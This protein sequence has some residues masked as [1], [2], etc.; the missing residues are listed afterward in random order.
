MPHVTTDSLIETFS[1]SMGFLREFEGTVQ[2]YPDKIAVVSGDSFITYAALNAK[3]NQLGRFLRRKGVSAEKIVIVYLDRSIE[4]IIAFLG[5]LKAGGVYL[6]LDP[7]FIPQYRLLFIADNAQ[8]AWVLTQVCFQSH[9]P[10][11]SSLV[12]LWEDVC[13]KMT[14]ESTNSFP[15]IAHTDNLAYIMYTS[16]STGTPKGVTV[17][18]K[19]LSHCAMAMQK[20]M[21]IRP[22]DVYLHTASFA[23]SSSIRQL[24]VPLF[25]GATLVIATTTHVRDPHELF[26]LVQKHNVTIMDVVPSFWKNC[27]ET[28]SNLVP[29]VR[30]SLLRNN[31]HLLVSASEALPLHIPNRW[32][33][34]GKEGVALINM[35]GQTETTGIVLT[36]PLKEIP[37]QEM[38]DLAPLGLPIAN[39][40]VSILT[41]HGDLIS[42]KGKGEIHVAGDGLARGYLN[43]PDLT[44]EKFTP[45]PGEDHPGSRMYRTGDIGRYNTEGNIQ[46][47]GRQD[48]QVKIRG[49]RVELGEIEGALRRHPSV[50]Q[51][52]VLTKKRECAEASLI[53]YVVLQTGTFFAKNDILEHLR[54]RLPFYMIPDEVLLIDH[55][56]L[57]ETGK[58]DRRALSEMEPVQLSSLETDSTPKTIWGKRIADIWKEVLGIEKLEVHDNFFDLG[59]QS[60][61][62]I[63]IMNRIRKSYN[64]SLPIQTI[65]DFPTVA[66]LTQKAEE[67]S[68]S[69]GDIL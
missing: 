23:F 26:L 51:G 66:G 28:L 48:T 57:T 47:L 38:R 37:P 9:L 36:Y 39:T 50:T 69:E 14:Q 25:C 12:L 4:L 16:G 42:D 2:Q 59:G 6:P 67:I 20:A 11:Q 30:S 21:G 61:K 29:T 45:D 56:P 46:F 63:Q 33:K 34:E 62:A 64:I 10:H 18:Y 53:A 55:V 13:P 32:N 40:R 24:T 15:Q 22:T 31:L 5:T 1:P 8:P 3:G 41:Q 43:H 58:I 19:N 7:H 27:L 65:F 54:I 44:A 60:L 68:K 35:Y 49:H 17:S 52:I